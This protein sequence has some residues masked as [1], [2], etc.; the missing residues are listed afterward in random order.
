MEVYVN[1]PLEI[2]IARDPKGIVRKARE[3]EADAVPGLQS[4]YEPP[5]KPELFVDGDR[6]MP[7]TAARRVIIKLAEK[8][9]FRSD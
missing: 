3:G 4:A 6:E 2:C 9:Y 8:G 1:C 5:E 7:E